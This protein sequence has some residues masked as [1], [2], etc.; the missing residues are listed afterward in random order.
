MMPSALV[1]LASLATAPEEPTAH[2]LSLYGRSGLT[3]FLSNA[4]SQGG[5]GGGVGL[6]D[7]LAERW[8]LQADL[9]AL[10]GLGSVLEARVGVGA[11]RRGFWRPAALVTFTGLFGDRLSFAFPEQTQPTRGPALGVGVTLAPVRFGLGQAQVSLLELSAGLG[12][13]TSGRGLLCGLT[14]LEVGVAL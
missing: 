8:L 13:D 9:N 10:T 14:L 5:V 12:P 7:T 1:L 2:Q 4:R 3:A 6:R 11:Q